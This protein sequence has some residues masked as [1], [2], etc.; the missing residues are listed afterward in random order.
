MVLAALVA[1]LFMLDVKL[2][3]LNGAPLV[4]TYHV[5]GWRFMDSNAFAHLSA[6][7]KAIA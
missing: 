2:P 7:P 3:T 4:P 6:T 1:M 5:G